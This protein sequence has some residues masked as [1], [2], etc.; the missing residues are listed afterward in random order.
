MS[1]IVTIII[2]IVILAALVLVHEVGHF[3]VAKWSGIRVDE[4]GLGFP[5]RLASWRPRGSETTYS[6]NAIP[7]GGFVKIFGETAEADESAEGEEAVDTS[8]SFIAKPATIQI[9]VLLAGIVF[10]LV[11]A[12]LLV[13]LGF[14]IG[15]PVPT[16]YLPGAHLSNI[17][18]TIVSVDP[19]SP[20]AKAGLESGDQIVGISTS[21][22]SGGI[23]ISDIQ[24]FTADHPGQSITISYDRGH[25]LDS[26]EVTPTF[27]RSI[28]R[29]AIGVSLESIGLLRLGFF[30]ALGHGVTLTWSLISG[31]AVALGQFFGQIFIG[32]A[33]LSEVAG[34]VGIAGLV[35]QAT[36]LGA[37]YVIS[38][39][40]L[41]SINLALINLIP[42]PALDGGRILFVIIEKIKGSPIRPAVGNAINTAGFA[43]L[44]LLML[45]VTYHDIAKLL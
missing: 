30:S 31:T 5:P 4:F 19:G 23:T 8:R 24:T 34:P 36:A 44:I 41:I 15:L 27:D 3:L 33:N 18:T 2:F 14:M 21:G 7:F 43:L 40:A 6:L 45:F 25:A 13:S 29:A 26:A 35:G 37:V 11:F 20:A 22:V 1:L 39:T 9:A 17:K 10:N 38:F 28:N 12:W 42:F 16:D 32:H